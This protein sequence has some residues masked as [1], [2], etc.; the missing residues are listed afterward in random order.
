MNK[1]D[2]LTNDIMDIIREEFGLDSDTDQD[3][4][5]YSKIHNRIREGENDT[6]V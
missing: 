3:D 4:F 1:I 6:S 2:E 5:L